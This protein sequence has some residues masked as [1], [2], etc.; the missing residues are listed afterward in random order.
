MKRFISKKDG[1]A[2]VTALLLTLIS[3]T[4][5]MSVMYMI[6]QNI[7][8]TGMNKRYRTA[9]EASYGGTDILMKELV[10]KILNNVLNVGDYG[11]INLSVDPCLQEKMT[12]PTASWS[13]SCSQLPEAKTSPDVR[14]DLT[15]TGGQPYNIYAKI[16]DTVVRGNSNMS[17]LQLEGGG[18]G[19]QN[20]VVKP[21]HLPYVYRLEIQAEKA[22]NEFVAQSTGAVIEKSNISVLYAW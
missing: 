11:L 13:V 9:L 21:K 10:P 2:L 7:S 6:T 8:T 1:I 19:E 22:S 18:V 17:G 5:V 3:L 14:F 12:N 4:I 20:P 16:I 15:S